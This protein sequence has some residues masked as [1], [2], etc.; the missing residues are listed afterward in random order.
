M[1]KI[2]ELNKLIKENICN[3]IERRYTRKDFF[4]FTIEE[5]IYYLNN[6]LN[7]MGFPKTYRWNEENLKS[8]NFHGT[9]VHFLDNERDTDGLDEMLK[10]YF[11][12]NMKKIY[13]LINDICEMTGDNIIIDRVDYEDSSISTKF[14]DNNRCIYF[15]LNFRID[16]DN[17]SVYLHEISLD[18]GELFDLFSLFGRKCKLTEKLFISTNDDKFYDIVLDTVKDIKNNVMSNLKYII[19]KLNSY[20]NYYDN[21]KTG[22]I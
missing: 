3:I 10:L 18:I 19:E 11:D 1:I 21:E 13:S 12:E 20:Y 17:E 7:K 6:F 14:L 2:K 16:D 8:L 15:I 22:D 4:N 9:V 5:K